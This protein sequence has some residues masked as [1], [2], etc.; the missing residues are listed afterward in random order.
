M[1]FDYPQ[2][3]IHVADAALHLLVDFQTLALTARNA[4]STE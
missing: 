4:S 3:L 1:E 2:A